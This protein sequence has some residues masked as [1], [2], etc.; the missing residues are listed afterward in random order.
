MNILRY[1]IS[2]SIVLIL[3]LLYPIDGYQSTGI[4]RL[5]RLEK[6]LDSTLVERYLKP[7]SFK[8]K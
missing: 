4:K 1:S 5:K 3:A 2:V 7:G 6:T 8:K